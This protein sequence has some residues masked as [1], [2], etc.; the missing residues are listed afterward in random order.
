MHNSESGEFFPNET[1]CTRCG[2]LT[3][4]DELDEFGECIWCQQRP[5]RIEQDM[6]ALG[7]SMRNEGYD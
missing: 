3:A 4:K 7:E 1:Y 5:E 2:E 6:R